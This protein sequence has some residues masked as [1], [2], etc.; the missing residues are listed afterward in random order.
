MP[1]VRIARGAA[2][3]PTAMAAYDAALA[4]A[5]A[6]EFN[7]VTVSSVIPVDAVLE[8]VDTLPDLGA[9]GDRLSVVQSRIDRPPGAEEVGVAG[10]GWA[11]TDSGSGVVYEATGTDQGVVRET[12]R[13]GLAHAASL[14]DWAVADSDVILETVEPVSEAHACAV[15]LAVLG[16]GESVS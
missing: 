9:V 7:L 11:R 8:V 10:L 4:A 6:H 2:T 16:R 1:T 14:R 12:L 3:G 5:G 13:E 15:T